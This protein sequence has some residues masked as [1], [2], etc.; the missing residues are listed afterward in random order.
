MRRQ[1]TRRTFLTTFGTATLLS[2][3]GCSSIINS[4]QSGGR[5]TSAEFSSSHT[6]HTSPTDR[7]SA[8]TTTETVE[9]TTTPESSSANTSSPRGELVEDFEGTVRSRWDVITG[10]YSIDT[11]NQYRGEQSV[12]LQGRTN[13]TSSNA[14]T[15]AVGIF[16]SFTAR[17]GI[18]LSSHDLTMAA[19]FEKPTDGYIS[20]E[21]V[22]P[23]GNLSSLHYTPIELDG[24]TRFDL[25]YTASDND[26][27]LKNV[28]ELR[29]VVNSP[30][31]P[32]NVAIDDI[33]MIPKPKKG[34]V[35]FQFDDS[36]ITAF[37]KAFP[38][39][40][41]H[42]WSGGVAVIPGSINSTEN[43]TIDHMETMRDAGWDMMSHPHPS[44][45]KPLPQLSVKRQE[46]LIRE[47][48]Q[49]LV[50]HG[51]EDGA[52]HV[53]APFGRVSN[54]TIEIMKKYHK[55]NYMFAGTPN[56]AKHPSN[57]YNISRV[58]GTAP[59]DALRSLLDLAERYNQMLIL[60][61]HEIGGDT[62][63]SVSMEHFEETLDY[64]GTKNMD[65]VSPSQFL[66]QQ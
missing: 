7:P 51:F 36:H 60:E 11:E 16:R 6:P 66:D 12:V 57:M 27:S 52:R 28:Q 54:E 2:L 53:V 18:D 58:F 55:A 1:S 47:S 22:T 9:T 37:T 38:Q 10:E 29:I 61:Y 40:K 8:Q 56:N 39:L 43:M 48:K 30:D 32:I 3:T 64:V 45:A 34:K 35:M 19:R 23:S 33:R 4:N 42:G 5:S 24:W 63:T 46:Q 25:G 49:F 15:N 17:G 13:G 62:S 44:V 59:S 31:K 65:V 41:Q 50:Q 21:F 20:V 14:K 26:P